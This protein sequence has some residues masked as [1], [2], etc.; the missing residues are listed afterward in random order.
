MPRL[1]PTPIFLI[2]GLTLFSLPSHLAHYESMVS[3]NKQGDLSTISVLFSF[4]K[5]YF[6]IERGR[7]GKSEGEKH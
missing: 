5:I 4:F 3:G 7:E 2:R 1:S 6:F